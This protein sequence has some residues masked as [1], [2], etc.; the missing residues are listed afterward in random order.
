MFLFV[1]VVLEVS[2]A[3]QE[4]ERE[5]IGQSFIMLGVFVLALSDVLD[6]EKQCCND[7][8]TWSFVL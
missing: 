5:A 8:L 4:R 3:C 6:H 1:L 7:T 2:F